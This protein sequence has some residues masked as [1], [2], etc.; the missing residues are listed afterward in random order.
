[1][2]LPRKRGFLY[3]SPHLRQEAAS[4]QSAASKGCSPETELPL[5]SI[6]PEIRG[7]N[8]LYSEGPGRHYTLSSASREEASAQT[9]SAARR[10][11][12]FFS[13]AGSAVSS[14][15]SSS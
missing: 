1:M 12:R 11:E 8:F 6:F 15:L 13:S 5:L 9:L 10:E 14:K 4:I 7:A 2:P 3:E